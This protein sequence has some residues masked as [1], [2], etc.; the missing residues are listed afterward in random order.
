MRRAIL[1]SKQIHQSYILFV[2]VLF[3]VSFR[4]VLFRSVL[5]FVGVSAVFGRFSS[6][7]EP[8]LPYPPSSFKYYV[9]SVRIQ[10]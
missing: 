7:F 2:N 8:N 9:S 10:I 1:I 6:T 5:F 3:L 4:V